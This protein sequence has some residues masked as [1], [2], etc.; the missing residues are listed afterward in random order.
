MK[1]CK[2]CGTEKPL[3]EYYVK[4][5]VGDKLRYAPT[6]KSCELEKRRT[7]HLNHGPSYRTRLKC[8]LNESNYNILLEKSQGKCNIC[9][10]PFQGK[11]PYLDH[12]HTTME[13]RGLLCNKCNTALGLA[14]DNIGVLEKMIDYLKLHQSG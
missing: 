1:T 14:N 10:A 5:K 9:G 3:T 13:S 11:E 2:S 12:D 8:G 7:Q 4:N 6:C